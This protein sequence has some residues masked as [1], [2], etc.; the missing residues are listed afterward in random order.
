[1]SFNYDRDVINSGDWRMLKITSPAGDW[2]IIASEQD[3]E[4]LI[5]NHVK[6]EYRAIFSRDELL[7]LNPV[8]KEMS[9]E[10]RQSDL[11]FWISTKVLLEGGRIAEINPVKQTKKPRKKK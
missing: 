11:K 7:K 5:Y 6:K 9:P 8:W 2:Y 3:R 10:Q 4:S 1:M